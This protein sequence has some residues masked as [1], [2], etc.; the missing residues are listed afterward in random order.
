ML[1]E[2]IILHRITGP[3]SCVVDVAVFFGSDIKV[4]LEELP[5][6]LVVAVTYGG[7]GG[8]AA[9]AYKTFILNYNNYA[10]TVKYDVDGQTRVYTIP[11]NRYV[12]VEH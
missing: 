8:D 6:I 4:P 12:M 11:A 3:F 9:A 5:E 1:E 7:K 2:A 10:V